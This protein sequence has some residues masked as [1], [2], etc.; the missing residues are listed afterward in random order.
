MG[1]WLYDIIREDGYL[2]IAFLMFVETVFPPIP[3]E[4]IMPLAGLEAARQELTLAGVI[5]AGT[6]GALFG[7]IF[8]Y[9]LA[10]VLGFDRFEHFTIRHGRWVTLTPQELYR[11][12]RWFDRHGGPTVAIGR[13]VPTMRSLISV[14]AGVLKMRLKRF[15]LWSALGTFIWTTALAVAGFA[16]GARYGTIDKYIAP[17]SNGVIAVMFV[18]YLY[19]VVTYR[20]QH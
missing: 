13:V 15:V 1:S 11:A 17:I 3:S 2:G 5:A 10:R 19:R 7:A 9:L 8:W 16:L 18:I 6:M 4:V 20:R 14:P 12:K